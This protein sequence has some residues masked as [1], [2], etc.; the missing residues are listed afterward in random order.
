[1]KIKDTL[2]LGKTAFPMRAGLP[3]KE[4][5]WQKDWADATLYEKRQE[6]NEGKPSFMLHDGPP[7]ANGN[8]HLG[9][10][11]NKISKD[12]IVRYKS[13]AGFR[14]PYVPGWDT[15]GLPIEQQLAK[16]G[17]KRKEMDL[18]DY[19]EECRKYAM[20]QVDMQRSDFKSL[21][22]LADW[23]RP[24][25]TLLPEYEAAQI[26]VFGKMAEKGYIYKGQKPIY[27]SPSSESSLA[28]AEI[29]YQDVRSA[30]IFVAFKAKDTKG[31]LPEDVE[32]VIWTT[33]PWTIPSNLGIFAHP[34]YDYSV[35]A[36]NGR[37]FVI[38]SEMLEAV[39]EKLEWEN[40]EVLQ[41]IKGSELE[42]MVTKHPFY[43]R[44]TLIMNADYVT[45]DSGTGLV[46]VAPGHGEDDYFASR[47]YKLPVLSP[48]DNRGYYTDEAPGLEGLFY[49]E[50]NKVVSKWLE[51]KD[52]LLKLEFFTHSYPHDWRTKKPVIFRA[53]PQW[54]AS[55]DDFRQNILDEVERV[56]WVI[57]W[58]KTRLFNMVRDRGD[59]VI[60]R[61]RAWGVPLPIFYGENGEPIITP[62]TTEHVAKL[63]AEFG[64][65]VWFEREAKD[66]L[67]EGFTHPASPNGEFTKEKDIMDVW[68]DSGSS[69]NGVLNER[70]YLSF[71]ADL[72]LE[73]SDQYRGW[74][75]S[76]ITTSVAVNGVAPYKAVLSQGFVL[77]GKGR[78]MS[79][80]IGNTIVPKDVT[81]KFGADILRLWVASIDTESDVRVSMDILSQVSEVYRKIRNT[82][83]FLIANTSDF[84]PKEDAID[85][86]ELRPVDKYMLVKFNELV[87][88]IRTAYDNYSFMTVYKSIINFIT[89]DLSSFYLDF[90]KDVVYIEAANSPE[91][92]SMQTVMYVILK[93]LVKILV[94]IL[95]H[96]A[97]E[98]WTYLEH[99]PEN[100]AYLA[101]MPE[102]AEIPGS[103]ELLGNWQEFLDFRDKILKALES[104]R[105]AKLIGKSLE[106]TV[107]IY[108]NEV[109]RTLLTAID[110][111][112]AQLLIVS[113]FVVAN[114][115]VNNAPE[116][117]MKF[118]DLAVLVEHAAGEVCDRCRRTAETVGHNANE[119]LKMLCEHCAH[120]VE[121]E[122]PE[123]LEEGFED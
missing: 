32:F 54:F 114:E 102:A 31:K 33:T 87:K 22:V 34:D 70:D 1:M 83:R 28:E 73:G 58:G 56:D 36:V 117:A 76:S 72:Y 91:R 19:L 15:H 40:P 84:N 27:W 112:V 110:E 123:I 68:F 13:M 24:Y 122:F 111:N 63:F 99:E 66:L 81:K 43:D 85:F 116:S 59:W 69:W 105:E 118:D 62:E 90:A 4:P 48:I 120:I 104:T 38:A 67:P 113:N 106:A 121:T 5:N 94:P 50:G 17:M 107:T 44:E 26:R 89:N 57:P 52:A 2:N 65:K 37:K 7:Y 64:S 18:L 115:P 74:F 6:L 11:L 53:T 46:H 29:E 41:T 51:E 23:D 49:D 79:K 60:S 100:F 71:P 97:E 77:D 25:L 3:N 103:E 10:S 101:E 96:T 42:Y 20:K 78:K 82:L 109:V 14:A 108:P 30:S 9:H 88:Q 8:I 61:Q 47:K 95:P 93:D 119:H 21:G 35:V 55:I 45:L 12:I 39:A 75:N 16:A 98:T 86:A 80:S 92:R